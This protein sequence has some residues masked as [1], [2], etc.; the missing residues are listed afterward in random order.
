M[1]VFL[2]KGSEEQLFT[3]K[4]QGEEKAPINTPTNK[5]RDKSPKEYQSLFVKKQT[6]SITL[7]KWRCP[8]SFAC[9]K[10]DQ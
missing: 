3:E 8:S 2:L 4:E 6:V 9:K 10:L 5:Q 7:Q 1:N